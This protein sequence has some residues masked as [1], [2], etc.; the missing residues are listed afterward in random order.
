M[1]H[2]EDGF[3]RRHL[4]VSASKDPVEVLVLKRELTAASGFEAALR[5]RIE[6]FARFQHP[7]FVRVRGLARLAKLEGIGVVSDRVTGTRLSRLLEQGHAL[8][9]TGA[10]GLTSQLI[11]ALAALHRG[12][13]DGWHGALAPERILIA[14]DGRLLVME[15]VLGAP[16][17]T[18][19]LTS[20]EC[21]RQLRVV[22]PAAGAA[23]LDQR[24]DLVQAGAVALAMLV[25]R[26]LGDG[27]PDRIGDS[28]SGS[29]PLPV[30]TA[31]DLLPDD[32]SRWLSRALQ[33]TGSES[34]ATIDEARL[35]LAA[36]LARLDETAIRRAIA[37]FTA[38]QPAVAAPRRPEPVKAHAPAQTSPAPAAA[39]APVPAPTPVPAAEP[40]HP[41]P[42]TAQAPATWS[43]PD[44]EDEQQSQPAVSRVRQ[45]LKPMTR[46]TVGVAAA[47]LMLLTT[48]G[49]FAAKRYLSPSN[50][51]VNGM[52]A[53]STTPPGATVVIDGQQRGHTPLTVP[54]PP[55]DHVLQVGLDGASRT[56]R[57]NVTPGAQLNEVLDLPK[58]VAATGQLQ[59][60]TEPSGAKVLVDGQRRGTS[61]L[62]VDNLMP[63]VHMVSVEGQ[64]GSVTQEVTI[65]GGS[66]ASLVVPLNAPEG[67]PVSGWIAISAPVDVQLFEKGQLLGS[68]R[69]QRIMA[70]VGKHDLDI[71]N[72]ALGYRVTRSVTVTPGQVTPVK[73]DPPKGALSVNAVPWAEVLIDGEK[74]GETP[75]GNVQLAI[76]PHEV[77]FRHPELGEQRTTVTVT[78]NAP[79]RVS[80][81]LRRKP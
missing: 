21:W 53:V 23:A 60:R 33:L 63:G 40:S 26:P 41:E 36:I 16:V 75:I 55:G 80:A 17:R 28:A 51:V 22:A 67:A 47:I 43:Q 71:V 18:L 34:F 29:A 56:V 2:F 61:P 50:S 30:R 52:M 6:Q 1:D 44:E 49:A 64:L 8:D 4:V 81:D 74:V 79:A 58:T 66:T 57:V 68:S 77:T 31:I 65:E 78:L 7:S 5:E 72:D 13:A 10:I 42:L 15:H 37:A 46:R 35:E 9:T 24:S 62:T 59:I 48:G 11:D 19:S 39:S 38:G 3:G 32:V 69:Q 70:A 20:R 25:G 27:Y 76:G 45:F 54:V 14:G 12:V 73:V